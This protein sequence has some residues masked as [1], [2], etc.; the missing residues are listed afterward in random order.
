MTETALSIVVPVYNEAKNL[1]SLVERLNA[2][3]EQLRRER[4]FSVSYVFVDD[5]SR[6][7]SFELLCNLNYGEQPARILQFSRNFGKEAALSAGIDAAIDADA[8]ILMD[9]DLQHP[10]E[11]VLEL[12]RIWVQDK[13]DSVYTYKDSRRETEG[14]LKSRFVN[15]FYW[16]INRGARFSITENAGDF[17]LISRRCADALRRLPES[18]RFMKG[19]YGWV[20]F[21]QRGIP[22]SVPPRQ[23]GLSS[24]N[25]MRLFALS[26]DAL[27]S[28][29]TAPLR[30]MA[31]AGLI[32]AVASAAYG[33][34][35]IL[36][37]LFFP[38]G[39]IGLASILTLVSFFGGVQIVFLGLIGEYV[40]KIVL[41][42]KRRPP[43]ILAENRMLPPH[44]RH[45]GL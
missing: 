43:Y 41:E 27:T 33:C 20:G 5:G 24:F 31:L 25:A 39:E 34:Y 32:T 36:E 30:L 38:S 13:V 16:I 26:F 17:R 29:T 9:A 19:L 11:L 3:A 14:F 15:L 7:G 4:G 40:G 1:A 10:P 42:A 23:H 21:S 18:E 22:M 2:I 28:F 37:R 8:I 12:V 45:A 6:D 44:K 35:I